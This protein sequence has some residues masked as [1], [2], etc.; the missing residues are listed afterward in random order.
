MLHEAVSE[1]YRANADLW[2][3]PASLLLQY[4]VLR[5]CVPEVNRA[6]A[7][8]NRTFLNPDM[9]LIL[10]RAAAMQ[11]GLDA[12]PQQQSSRRR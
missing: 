12:S 2:R 5:M 6:A 4:V 1:A 9:F 11:T 3:M 7:S 8:A 10:L